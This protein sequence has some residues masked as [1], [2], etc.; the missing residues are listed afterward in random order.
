[1]AASEILPSHKALYLGANGDIA[2]LD[3]GPGSPYTPQNSQSL[4]RVRYSGINPGDVRHFWM[5]MNSFVMGY[6]FSGTV[7][8]SGPSSPFSPGDEVLGMTFPGHQRAMHAGAHQAFLLADPYMTWRR[9]ADLQ[10]RWAASMATAAQTAADALFN[11]LGFGLEAAGVDGNST[12]GQALLIWGGSSSV[13]WAAL[14]LAR[15]AGFEA[16]FVTASPANHE[17][18]RAAGAARCFD[19]HSPAV[20]HDIRRAA[21]DLALPLYAV[22]DAVGAGLG[23]FEPPR[24]R[25]QDFSR[26]SPAV[27]KLCLADGALA[28][29]EARLCCALPVAQDADWTFALFSRKGD[30][31]ETQHPGWWQ[32]QDKVVSWLIDNHE[33][34]WRPLPKIS[35]VDTAEG[36]VVALGDA[37]DGKLSMQKVLMQHPLR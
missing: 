34:A 32:R 3:M 2:I 29:G 19:Y 14:H 16:V 37:F 27:A 33:S 21:E 35:V 20:V 8:D 28:R 36:A 22:F 12:R 4:V 1:M 5:G 10:A 24:A 9:P 30:M 13:G 23:I 26:S 25:V 11:C 7:V 31:Q 6:D 17:A 15:A 18:L